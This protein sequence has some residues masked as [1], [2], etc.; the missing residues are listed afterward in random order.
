M[1]KV[2]PRKKIRA[3]FVSHSPR[4]N[5]ET[6][7]A[8]QVVEAEAELGFEITLVAPGKSRLTGEVGGLVRLRELPYPKPANSPRD[9]LSD[10]RWLRRLIE[11]SRF[12]LVHSSRSTAHLLA[13][14]ARPRR[15]PLIHLRG[16]AKRPY[17]HPFNRLLYRSL[18]DAVIVSSGRV[19]GWVRD[20]LRV[21]RERIHRILAPV[22][23]ERFRALS[24]D[25]GLREELGLPAR[26]PLLVKVARLA[27]VKGHSYLLEA[28]AQVHREIPEAVLVLVGN[29][30]K[31]EPAGLQKQA[32][33]L[34]IGKS[35]FFP[36]RREDIPR[37]LST[38]AVCVSS[39]IG[40]EENSRAVS[41]YMA[42]GR[43]VAATRVGV[44]P[45]L[46]VDGKTGFLVSP[47]D[48]EAMASALIKLLRDPGLS[49]RMGEAGRIRAKSE[50]SFAS[51]QHHLD[52]VLRAG[53]ITTRG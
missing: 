46:V 30:W 28:M 44:I 3:L 2:H 27:P 29:P 7:Y 48:P 4:W 1:E 43:P 51:F 15:I 25:R 14:L 31:G 53:G 50:F 37:I 42:C 45:E 35:V 52:G 16:G 11:E 13:A 40:S 38:A 39:S 6:E 34:G 17:G 10:L 49:R 19:E 36:G 20:R 24:P 41:E 18:T 22:D 26:G 21:P 5:G 9:F 32:R 12:D 23:T 33:N 47:G 8:S